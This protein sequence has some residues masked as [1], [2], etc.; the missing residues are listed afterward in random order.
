MNHIRMYMHCRRCIAELPYGESP[1]DYARLE[2]G[3]TQR[4]W[5][6]WCNRHDLNVMHIDFEGQ[7]HPAD[8]SE[9]GDFIRPATKDH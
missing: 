2:V 8:L 7:Q 1:A 5:Q 9:S 6:V 3:F 4:G